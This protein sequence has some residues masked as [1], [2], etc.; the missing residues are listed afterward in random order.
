MLGG[1]VYAFQLWRNA[2][3]QKSV[4]DEG[5]YLLKGYLFA[6]GQ[7][8][9]FQQ[10][11]PWTNQMP[12]AFLP[13]GYIQRIFGPGLGTGRIFAIGLALTTLL[14][15]WLLGRRLGGRWW[16]AAL[17]WAFA[18]NP[19]M[20]KMYSLAV[21]QVMAATLLA[22]MLVLALGKGRPT[23][24]L[25][26]AGILS[27]LL[28]MTRI[29][30]LPVYFI[31]AG[32]VLWQDGKRAA[33]VVT[34]A[35]GAVILIGH[36]LLWPNILFMW[37]MAIPRE[38]SPFLESW[39]LPEN[40]ERGWTLD[41]GLSGR[42]LSLLASLRYHFLA[43]V[44]ALATCL[45]IP[46][47]RNWKNQERFKEFIFLA[48]IFWGL[49]LAHAFFSLVRSY[50]VYCLAGYLAFFSLTGLL[51]IV[52]AFPLWLQRTSIWKQILGIFLAI[53]I[54]TA[55]GYG[56]FENTGE[57]FLNLHIPGVLLGS[58]PGSQPVTLESVLLNKFGWSF[59]VQR[60]L[61]PA[62]FGLGVGLLVASIGIGIKV[63]RNPK[64]Q[65]VWR[66]IPPAQTAL[67]IMLGLGAVFNL[68]PFLGGGY[69]TYDCS[70]N[71]IRS[72]EEVGNY[73]AEFIPSDSLV[74]WKGGLSIAPLLYVP[75]VR[76]YPAQMEGGYTF[77]LK[78][79]PDQLL[80]FGY[81]SRPIAHQWLQETNFV[82]VEE[83]EFGGWL[84]EA[85]EGGPYRQVALSPPVEPCRSGS[86]IMVFERLP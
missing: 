6:T 19:A 33:L 13:W 43:V 8:T 39:R 15:A 54:S 68:S 20:G 40:L 17:V 66:D 53:L 21:S 7:Y 27:G 5:A 4:L 78:G 51:M 47:R 46:S 73:L 49:W 64:L 38:L 62:L 12:L 25:I 59:Q 67:T 26:T 58:T 30:L 23:W 57:G 37:A 34:F 18:W 48:T 45:F 60:R 71:I 9:P 79:E 55:I 28:V 74:Y 82:L 84:R 50:C 32:Y 16:A 86:S 11:G 52:T 14:A 81:W 77:Y 75:E 10:Y 42:L 22:W 36:L 85:I 83:Q 31:L 35:G 44:G 69:H 3:S 80:K 24:Q 61:V 65:T 29:N 1:T 76:V 41:T 63:A 2:L 72:Y 70:G 56:S